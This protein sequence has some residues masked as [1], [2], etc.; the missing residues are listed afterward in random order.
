MLIK[1][2]TEAPVMCKVPSKP[3]DAQ[4]R[5]MPGINEVPDEDWNIIR[6]DLK[7]KLDGGSLKELFSSVKKDPKNGDTYL[8]KTF[9]ELSATE[10]EPVVAAT[11]DLDLLR[12]WKKDS[13][14]EAM[15]YLISKR[16]DAVQAEFGREK[17]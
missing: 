8:G 11:W 9:N 6:K 3:L 17:K 15:G 10:A 5:L 2:E 1:L 12:A 7:L 16:I 4:I 14:T 13:K